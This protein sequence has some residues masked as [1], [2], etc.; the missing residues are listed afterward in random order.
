MEGVFSYDAMSY[1]SK[2][3]PQTHPDNLAMLA[4]LFGMT[5]ASVENCRVLELGCG[6]GSNLISQAY[7]LPGANFVGVDLAANH[8]AAAREAAEE[9]NVKNIEFRQMDITE[10]TRAEF[11]EFD[12]VIA[13]GL[14]S[15][16]PDSVRARILPLCREMLAENGIGY[17]SYNAY[18]GAHQFRLIGDMMGFYTRHILEPTEKVTKSVAFLAFLAEHGFGEPEY[19]T[20]LKEKLKQVSMRDAAGVFHDHLSENNKAFYFHEF[21]AL[22]AEND[23]RFF[24]EAELPASGTHMLPPAARQFLESITDRIEREQYRDFM[25]GRSFRQTVFCRREIATNDEPQAQELDKL[26]VSA[27]IR[28]LSAEP[29]LTSETAEKFVDR[30]GTSIEINRP[31]VKSALFHLGLKEGYAVPFPE[32]LRESKRTLEERGCAAPDWEAEMAGA[33]Q[34][35]LQIC[36][37]TSLIRLSTAEPLPRVVLSDK[38]KVS[39][40]ARWQLRRSDSV[41]SPMNLSVEVRDDFARRLLELLDGTRDREDLIAEMWMYFEAGGGAKENEETPAKLPE[42]TQDLL[43]HFEQ[44]GLLIS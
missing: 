35:L 6:T 7:N 13:H 14:F 27:H 28:P 4:T 32:L 22:L 42:L 37:N 40:L 36:R 41:L 43:K 38:P 5:P 1:S 10:M 30:T 12:F 18:P 24:S 8:I 33:R 11:G 15:W 17:V 34:V 26:F 9:L 16:V 29:D 2:F 31:S 3:F 20:T 44:T 25:R 39:D 21:A 19:R 23:L